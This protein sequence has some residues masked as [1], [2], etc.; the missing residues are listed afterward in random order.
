VIVCD[1]CGHR[2]EA[3][4]RFCSNCGNR[5]GAEQPSDLPGT[6]PPAAGP[7]PEP[8]A[9]SAP[10]EPASTPPPPTLPPQFRPIGG[11]RPGRAEAPSRRDLPPTDPEWRM[12]PVLEEAPPPR[13]RTWLWIVGGLLG[14][15]LLSCAGL[16]IFVNFTGTGQRLLEEA[17]VQATAIQAT[18]VQQTAEAGG[19]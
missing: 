9:T 15:C 3:G 11:D 8:S 18:A 10:A 1:R 4:S 17:A 19:Q 16:F 6:P 12:S 7:S 13:R 2:N 5:L 14:L